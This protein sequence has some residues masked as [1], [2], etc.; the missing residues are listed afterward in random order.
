MNQSLNKKLIS[1]PAKSKRQ[2]RLFALAYLHKTGR[3]E[4]EFVSEEVKKLSDSLS[5][6][7]LKQYAST[8]Q[9]KRRKDG[10]VGK[11]DAIPQK[12]EKD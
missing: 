9:K 4:G 2:R 7:K 1:M 11:R 8:N 3:L 6:E 12:V 10:S 5:V